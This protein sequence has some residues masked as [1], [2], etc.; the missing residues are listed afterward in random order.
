[1]IK[2]GFKIM[3]TGGTAKVLNANEVAAQTINKIHEGRPNIADAIKNKELQL[4]INTPAGKTSQHDD[5]YIRM[6]AIQ[7]K[8]PYITTLAA[9]FASVEGIEAVKKDKDTLRSL[10]EYHSLLAKSGVKEEKSEKAPVA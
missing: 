1:L 10:Q 7:H 4:I 5:G 3:A 2:L 8:I 9:A 6:M